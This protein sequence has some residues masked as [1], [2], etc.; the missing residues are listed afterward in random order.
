MLLC[1]II[2]QSVDFLVLLRNYSLEHTEPIE[3]GCL[4]LPTHIRFL[5][6]LLLELHIL[7]HL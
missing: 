5:P 1:K 7:Q 4:P 2:G 3:V 6:L